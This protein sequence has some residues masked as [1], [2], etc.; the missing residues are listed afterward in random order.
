MKIG[1]S[2]C[3]AGDK[4]RYDGTDKKDE[5]LLKLLQGHELIR[6]CPE[7]EAGFSIPRDTLEISGNR[8]YSRAGK[9]CTR[10][11]QKGAAKS[12]EKIRDCDFV[13]LKSRSPS[14]GLYQIYDGTFS[15]KMTEGNGVFARL[16]L[17]NGIPV[18]SENDIDEIRRK[19]A[20]A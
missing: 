12:L 6:I 10:K 13:I 8:V 17:E 19:T 16:C 5:K 11:L 14:C 4:V 1:I 2:A 18:Y 3:L 7:L 20:G 9:D 15:G